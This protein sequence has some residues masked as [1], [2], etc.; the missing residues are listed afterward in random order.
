[1]TDEDDLPQILIPQQ[2]HDV[3]DVALEVDVGPHQMGSFGKPR[4]SRRV[5]KVAMCP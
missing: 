3:A 5:D 2:S 1:V 4:Q